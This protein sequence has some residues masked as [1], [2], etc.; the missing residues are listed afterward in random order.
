MRKSERF[1]AVTLEHG[2]L[3]VRIDFDPQN[4]LKAKGF[5]I[6]RPNR[7]GH[8]IDLSLAELSRLASRAIQRREVP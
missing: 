5:Y 8:E 2:G 6:W 4:A 1:P 7:A 3:C